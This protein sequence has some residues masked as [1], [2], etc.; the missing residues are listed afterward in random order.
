MSGEFMIMETCNYG[1]RVFCVLVIPLK[2]IWN[3]KNGEEKGP[4]EQGRG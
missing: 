1:N 4:E 3:L 2:F